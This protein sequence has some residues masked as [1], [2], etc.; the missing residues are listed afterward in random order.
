MRRELQERWY[1]VKL[2]PPRFEDGPVAM[3]RGFLE[4]AAARLRLETPRQSSPTPEALS[5][6]GRGQPTPNRAGLGVQRA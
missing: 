4:T 6:R 1:T 3:D 2:E 5:G